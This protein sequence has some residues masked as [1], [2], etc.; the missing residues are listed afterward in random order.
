M[1]KLKPLIDFIKEHKVKILS[2]LLF[3]IW[4]GSCSKGRSLSKLER[5]NKAL[6]HQVDSLKSISKNFPETLRIEKLK[7]HQEYDLWISK[8]DRGDQ[9]MDLHTNFVKPK[10]QE[11]SK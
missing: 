9:L 1:E 8:K 3:I 10:I 6:T 5:K 2:A 7:I 4:V 11:L